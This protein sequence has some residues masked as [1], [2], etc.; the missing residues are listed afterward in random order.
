VTKKQCK[1]LL[2]EHFTE[3]MNK[4][5]AKELKQLVKKYT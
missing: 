2:L 1:E 5:S 3:Q 4:L